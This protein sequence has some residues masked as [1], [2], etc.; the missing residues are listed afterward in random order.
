MSETKKMS[1]GL[2]IIITL[3][4]I[5][6]V[7]SIFGNAIFDLKDV[8]WDKTLFVLLAIVL[9]GISVLVLVIWFILE[10]IEK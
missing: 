7:V 1:E 5:S 9:A 2:K 3:I 4:V 10:R 8:V 6:F